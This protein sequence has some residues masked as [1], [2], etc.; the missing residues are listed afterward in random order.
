MRLL[1]NGLV[2]GLVKF[3]PGF[4][5]PNPLGFGSRG[6]VSGTPLSGSVP[7]GFPLGVVRKE[8]MGLP[9][10][11]GVDGIDG[12]DGIDGVGGAAPGVAGG[13]PGDAW[14]GA[15]CEGLP[16]VPELAPPEFGFPESDPDAGEV[17]N[18]ELAPLEEGAVPEEF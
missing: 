9:G 17:P 1:E 2:N 11:E 16:G 15:V 5:G 12:I 18:A 6:F 3:V 13:D 14:P 7:G 8:G 4:R 10:M